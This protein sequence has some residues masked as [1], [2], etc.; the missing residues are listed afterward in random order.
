MRDM[1]ARRSIAGAAVL[2]ALVLAGPVTGPA[3]AQVYGY[4]VEEV[5]A[6]LSPRA[7]L[8]RLGRQGYA[9]LSHPR[10]DGETYTLDAESPGG[11]PVRLVVDARSGRI[12]DRDRLEAPLTPPA[13]I[14]SGRRPGYGWTDEARGY[15]P[16]S[17]PRQGRGVP[18]PPGSIPMPGERAGARIPAARPPV[19][20]APRLATREA[21][22]TDEP[23]PAVAAPPRPAGP[24]P[25]G[26]NPD[27]PAARG[28]R[29]PDGAEAPR[30]PPRPVAAR[31]ADS[32]AAIDRRLQTPPAEA[33]PAQSA[34]PPAADSKS[35]ESKA[36]EAKSAESKP[37]TGWTTPP[38][39][40]RPV[41]VIGG[42]TQVP[43]KDET[44][45]KE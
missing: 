10:F 24:N 28:A 6:V 7:V 26:L 8:A 33:K 35:A 29:S 45:S 15:D 25:L 13:P 4:T 14:P 17:D 3:A 34:Q 19:D 44:V 42:V 23:R 40:N 5:D 37:A 16:E 21:P 43:A 1:I 27:S 32:P 2:A 22:P 12:L 9:P 18:L 20:P 41:R 31:P 36:A 38:E 30:K 39:G 11:S